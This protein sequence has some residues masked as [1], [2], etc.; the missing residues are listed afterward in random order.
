M[1]WERYFGSLLIDQPPE[2]HAYWERLLAFQ[3][4]LDVRD[5]HPVHPLESLATELRSLA[6]REVGQ[7]YRQL[8]AR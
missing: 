2:P 1:N 8:D 4:E 7:R 5:E 3:Q 6:G